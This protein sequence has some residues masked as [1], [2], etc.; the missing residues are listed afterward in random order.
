MATSETTTD[1]LTEEKTETV[2]NG[3]E[4]R[5]TAVSD[6]DGPAKA[7]PERVSADASTSADETAK[8]TS[9]G[10][11]IAG[12]GGLVGAALGLASITGTSVTDM[13]RARAELVGQID[14]VT[15]GG[16][17]ADQIATLYGT[18]WHT[19][20]LVNG[21]VAVIATIIGLAVVFGPARKPGTPA[22]ARAVAIAGLVL[23]VLGLLVSAGMALDLF[24]PA[25]A[26]PAMP[27][28]PGMP[29]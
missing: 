28:M 23:G 20:A 6:Q 7:A 1:T 3:E 5:A 11:A 16:A 29:R 19:A 13:I 18:P 10:G 2:T 26:M 21:I 12:A 17:G 9:D 4:T 27:S 24:A 25:P 14:A 8:K 15:G 22:W